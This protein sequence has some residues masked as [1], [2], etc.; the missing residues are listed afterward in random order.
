MDDE[1]PISLIVNFIGSVNWQQIF[2]PFSYQVIVELLAILIL[3]ILTALMCSTEVA[4]FSIDHQQQK[5]MEE[6]NDETDKHILSLLK[7]P[8]YLLATLVFSITL[9]SL[10]I[11]LIFEN[12]VVVVFQ[13][14]FLEKN[15]VWEFVIK[16][17]FETFIIV[18]FAEVIPKVYA[19]QKSYSVARSLVGLIRIFRKLFSPIIRI[20]V[21]TTNFIEKRLHTTNKSITAQDLDE[22]IDITNTD[23]AYEN[24]SKI[25]KGII[26]FGNI[27]VKQIMKSRLDVV[28]VDHDA[29]FSELLD[30][31]RDSG[32]SRIPVYNDDVD[33]VVGIIYAKDLLQFLDEPKDFNWNSFI[34]PAKFV[35]EN[36]KIDVLLEE[37]QASRV[38]MA[39][40]V[41]EY[42]GTNGIITLEDI[43]EE[44]IGDIR[45]EY[46]D[47]IEI[48]YKK[49]D[50]HNYI[51]EGRTA[52]NDVC[53]II[54][55][56]TD[57]F[58]NIRGNA[59]S[60][61]GLILELNAE[62]PKLNQIINYKNYSFKV[63]EKDKTRIKQIKITIA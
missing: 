22:A 51:F 23:D 42:G 60:L 49:I 34:K 3:L 32:Y 39:I 8:Q 62:L 20:L 59:D 24:D 15:K 25:L 50:D 47:V 40:V 52:I 2:L 21:A 28:A 45:D 57:T 17:A 35:P 26:K 46:D 58:E 13:P 61:A 54:N 18:L 56:S 41:D 11:V 43:L 55:T 29:N 44:V 16:V 5:K 30:I 48:D 33:K 12:L 53:K 14:A 37:F 19:S 9:F 27:T 38:H 4:F 6:S 7:Q 10:G 1:I 31:V 36:K 63:V